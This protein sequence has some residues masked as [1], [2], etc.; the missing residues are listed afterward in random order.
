MTS[1]SSYSSTTTR[2]TGLVS[3]LDVD[4]IV[5]SLMDAEEVP[6]NRLEQKKQLAEWKQDAYREVSTSL[7]AFADEYFSY[8]NS[9]SNM[10]SLSTYEQ[11]ALTSSDDSVVEIS[12]TSSSQAG[13]HRVLVSNLATAATYRSSTVTGAISAASAADF[14]KA[15]GSS[16]LLTID[17]RSYTVDL[18]EN[19]TDLE[20]LQE[21]V[22]EAVGSGKIVISDTN[23]DGTGYLT[24][25]KADDSGIGTIT[26]SDPESG[27]ALESLGFSDS[28][29][30]SNY[31]DTSETLADIGDQ[32]GFSF[33]SSGNI[34]LTINDVDFEFSSSTTLEEMMEEINDSEAGVT[35]SYSS[36]SDSFVL[37]ANQTGAGKTLGLSETGSTFLQ[38]VGLTDYTAGEDAVATI[39]GVKCTRSEN[40]FTIDGLTY[41]LKAESTE[42]QRVSVTQDTDAILSKI[43]SFVEDYNTLIDSINTTISEEYDRDYPPLTD[44][45]KEEMSDDEIEAWEEKAKTG[46]LEDDEALTS[47]LQNLRT[48][49][50]ESVAGVSTH[51]TEIGITTSSNY[52]DKGKL[53]I[54]TDALQEA[55]AKDPEGVASLFAQQSAAYGG[56]TTVVNLTSEQRKVRS[57]EEGLAYRVYD[58]LQDNISTYTGIDGQKGILIEKAG[59]KGDGSE[60]DNTLTS[61]IN[62]YEE[63]IDE[64]LDKLAD[65]EDYYYEK[66]SAME[67]FINQM[68]TQINS[69]LSYL[70]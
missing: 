59:Q 53:V 17:G 14:T 40:S 35:M 66:Y 15:E 7:K 69:L 58:I 13:S 5:E 24:I 32:L 65:K 12:T 48:A 61:Q 38:T 37:T 56:T 63:E 20:S 3:G 33:D 2:V 9:S 46:I 28:A 34:G 43:T 47:L 22:D 36:T 64:M 1:I 67:T 29:T 70:E 31:L 51:L 50:Y 6:L 16:F 8:T 57:S 55:I 62:N 4:S 42:T 27:G 49:L 44:D 41:N 39:D 54:D 30:L 60:Y 68:N 25:A 21:A 26:V 23:G 11:F 52:E 45:Q 10:L 18:D 19:V